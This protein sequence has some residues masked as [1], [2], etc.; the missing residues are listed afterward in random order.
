MLASVVITTYKR[1]DFAQN[2]IRSVLK[3]TYKPLE[4]IVVEDGTN[5]GVEEWI[6]ENDFNQIKYVRHKTN[7]G[8]P[9]ARNTGLKH[10]AGKYIAFIDDDDEWE[11]NKIELQINYLLSKKSSKTIYYCGAKTIDTDNKILSINNPS[12]KGNIRDLIIKP[13]LKTIPSSWVLKRKE[14]EEIGG[15]DTD[16]KTGIDHDFWMKLAKNEFSADYVNNTLVIA[17]QSDDQM[18]KVVGKRINGIKLYLNKWRPELVKWYG[19]SNANKYINNYYI[20]VIGNLG[21]EMFK[22]GDTING[23]KCLIAAFNYSRM[24][25]ILSRYFIAYILGTKCFYMLIKVR[26]KLINSVH[27]ILL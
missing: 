13:G 7:L 20:R 15:F 14:L 19:L 2:A 24:H 1:F 27:R 6:I 18:T 16:L 22:V 4:I 10:S 12:L 8:L 21:L 23:K 17:K 11:P 5:C 26:Q 25:F 9:S 3:Q